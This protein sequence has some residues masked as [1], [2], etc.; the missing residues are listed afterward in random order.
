MAAEDLTCVQ[1]RLQEVKAEQEL[2]PV[3]QAVAIVRRVERG[4]VE[5]EG[6]YVEQRDQLD[7]LK[8]MNQEQLRQVLPTLDNN[9][10]SLLT[11]PRKIWPP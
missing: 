8:A 11:I 4:R 5:R 7:R 9:A 10:N 3:V 6:Q 2:A 1:V